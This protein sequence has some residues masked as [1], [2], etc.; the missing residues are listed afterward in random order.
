[1]CGVLENYV[2]F[3][4]Q[5]QL[6]QPVPIRKL[7]GGSSKVDKRQE[8]L[9]FGISRRTEV[10]GGRRSYSTVLING[11]NSSFKTSWKHRLSGLYESEEIGLR[12]SKSK[13]F[14]TNLN[15]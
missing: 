13:D 15:K 9:E 2:V 1:M 6:K 3:P 14:L 10:Q 4:V 12:E 11:K 7:T 5:V 8:S